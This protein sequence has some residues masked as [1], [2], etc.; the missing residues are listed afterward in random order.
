MRHLWLGIK[1]LCGE[2]CVCGEG[3]ASGRRMP[4]SGMP[5]RTVGKPARHQNRR[6]E[7]AQICQSN[8]FAFES[9]TDAGCDKN[10]NCSPIGEFLVILTDSPRSYRI[11][12]HSAQKQEQPQCHPGGRGEGGAMRQPG[13]RTRG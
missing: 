13:G 6:Y 8:G 4:K 5:R 3:L 7:T 1:A 9:C 11:I 2:S 12:P 10:D